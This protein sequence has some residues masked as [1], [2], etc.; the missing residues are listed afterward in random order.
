MNRPS[1]RWAFCGASAGIVAGTA[2]SIALAG[3]AVGLGIAGGILGGVIGFFAGRVMD[4]RLKLTEVYRQNESQAASLMESLRDIEELNR[5]LQ[6]KVEQRTGELSEANEALK[7][8]LKEL[9]ESQ[10]KALQ[11]ERQAAVGVLAGGMAHEMNNPINAIRLSHQALKEDVGDDTQAL[12]ILATAERAA[13]RCKRIVNELLSFSRD[14]Q[15]V[16]P[17]DITDIVDRTLTVFRK[18]APEGIRVKE[19]FAADVPKLTLDHAQM[20]QALLNLLENASDAMQGEGQID[21]GVKHVDSCAVVT[22]RDRGPGMR[23]DVADKV[24]DPFFTTKSGAGLGLGLSITYQLVH[25]NGGT[26]E[27]DSQEGNGTTF[28]IRFPQKNVGTG[29]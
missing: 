26:I 25:R 5:Q 14:P 6:S 10:K 8:A 12:G 7:K 27:V 11:Q 16:L 19:D 13:G 15:K 4:Y 24:F 3:M 9:R 21:V 2:G 29:V 22:V 23:P 18:D 28:T 17:G 1:H 20:Q